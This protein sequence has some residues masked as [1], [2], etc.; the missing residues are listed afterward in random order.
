M[1]PQPMMPT[2]SFVAMLVPLSSVLAA[3]SERRAKRSKSLGIVVL[4]HVDLAAV[5]FA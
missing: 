4:H 2:P 5:L 3:S 1:L